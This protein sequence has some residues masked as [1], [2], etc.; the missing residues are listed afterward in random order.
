MASE[1]VRERLQNRKKK[2]KKGIETSR[3][4]GREKAQKIKNKAKQYQS[5]IKTRKQVISQRV[6]ESYKQKMLNRRWT[7]PNALC[8]LRIFL[9]PVFAYAILSSSWKLAIIS[10]VVAMITDL[11][12]G[13]LARVRNEIT[14][15]GKLLDPLADK[16]FFGLAIIALI[17][18]LDISLL[19]FLVL[20]RDIL[21]G[22]GALFLFFTKKSTIADIEP[23]RLGK[24]LNWFQGMAVALIIGSALWHHPSW[25]ILLYF[26]TAI[27]AVLG[28]YCAVQ[29]WKRVIRK[30]IRRSNKK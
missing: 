7:V 16:T 17:I 26:L 27:T 25:I 14:H 3:E 24:T 15:L 8:L 28:L 21:I 5:R 20:T 13:Y 22:M 29:Q 4:R 23:T 19:V 10:F 2:I 9:A 12:D 18:R 1:R 30:E 11:L 6:Q